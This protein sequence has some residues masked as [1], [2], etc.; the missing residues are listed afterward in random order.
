M[1]SH[2]GLGSA[3]LGAML[4]A[5][6]SAPDPAAS[7]DTA[8]AAALESALMRL[9]PEVRPH[10]TRLSSV[11][12]VLVGAGFWL[13]YSRLAPTAQRLEPEDVSALDTLYFC[14]RL[15][16]GTSLE[17][18]CE[19]DANGYPSSG[20]QVMFW[21]PPHSRGRRGFTLVE[22]VTASPERQP[23]WDFR[24]GVGGTR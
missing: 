21:G 14:Q 20:I 12:D 11:A 5:S 10:A 24:C 9:P 18:A 6:P 15:I 22:Y 13:S 1:S 2:L 3:V 7:R 8:V 23:S 16:P 17:V 19:F 4:A